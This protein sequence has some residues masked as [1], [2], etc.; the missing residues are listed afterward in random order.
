MIRNI[1]FDMGGV[2]IDWTPDHLL[3]KLGITGEDR[4]TLKREVFKEIEWVALDAG[5]MSNDEAFRLVS[6]RLEERL[7][8]AAEFMIKRWPELP[9]SEKEGIV[10]LYKE[11]REKDYKLYVLSNADIKQKDYF[12]RVPGSE[13]FCGRVT[14]AEVDLLKPDKK[15]YEHICEKYDLKKEECY[16]VDDVALNVY[17][18]LEYGFKGSVYFDT[19]RLRRKMREEG[20]DVEE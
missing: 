4:E 3:D 18:A 5:T 14:S 15:I 6:K 9:F 10:A 7:W 20:I 2:M 16:F 13:Y 12:P 11:L 19:K 8:P 1:I 17:N